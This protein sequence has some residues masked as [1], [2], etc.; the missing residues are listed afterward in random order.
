MVMIDVCGGSRV[1]RFLQI[2]V[3]NKIILEETPELPDE[4]EPKPKDDD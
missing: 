4:E 3:D 2:M 1:C